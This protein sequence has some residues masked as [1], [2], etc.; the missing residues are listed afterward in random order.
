MMKFLFARC[1]P[2][3]LMNKS[4]TYTRGQVF[5]NL[6]CLRARFKRAIALVYVPSVINRSMINRF[7]FGP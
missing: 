1:K 4:L 6:L 3:M 7:K 2:V 5:C